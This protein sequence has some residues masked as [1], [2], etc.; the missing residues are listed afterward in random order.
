MVYINNINR[1]TFPM[2]QPHAAITAI[3]PRRTP[4]C[5]TIESILAE[6][7]HV[8]NA[9]LLAGL[10]STYPKVTATTV[11]RATVRLA[12]RNQIRVAPAD[13]D[14]SIRYDANTEPHD[15]F[16]CSVCGELRDTDVIDIVK[17]ALEGS[18]EGCH[19]EGRLT[20][21]GIC[22]KCRENR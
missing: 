11:H 19:I 2:N 5:D 1:Y 9:K 13:L 3:T 16:M 22:N 18:I 6:F 8:T 20:I 17:P 14:G 7:G 4:Y 15:H 12:E 21:G 10:R